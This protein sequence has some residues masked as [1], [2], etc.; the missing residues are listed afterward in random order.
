[1]RY[2]DQLQLLKVRWQRRPRLYA[3]SNQNDTYGDVSAFID[4]GKCSEEF[5]MNKNEDA[6]RL[7]QQFPFVLQ[8]LCKH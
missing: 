5:P 7:V 6:K 4:K 3:S 8:T 1:M 2:L